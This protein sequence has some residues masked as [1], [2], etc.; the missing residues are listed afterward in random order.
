ML[1]HREIIATSSADYTGIIAILSHLNSSDTITS[2]H[3][4]WI[5]EV[6]KENVCMQRAHLRFLSIW[7]VY[8]VDLHV[9]VSR[10]LES[11][12]AEYQRTMRHLIVN[13]SKSHADRGRSGCKELHRMRRLDIDRTYIMTE[14]CD[15]SY[16]RW[17]AGD[18]RQTDCLDVYDDFIYVIISID[19]CRVFWIHL[20]GYIW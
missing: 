10:L 6:L 16:A 13:C 14:L 1:S 17:R 18:G 9:S 8:R 5:L 19:L 3:F 11:K 2:C 4:I 12:T 7:H 15:V 20:E